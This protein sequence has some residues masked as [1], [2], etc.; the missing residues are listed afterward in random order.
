MSR[1]RAGGF[2]KPIEI[3]TPRADK[4]TPIGGLAMDIALGALTF[5]AVVLACIA[6]DRWSGLASV[7][8]IGIVGAVVVASWLAREASQHSRRSSPCHGSSTGGNCGNWIVRTPKAK[9]AM[10]L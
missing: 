1:S 3:D 10:G 2:L 9:S 7:V 5:V 4:A 8:L 6:L